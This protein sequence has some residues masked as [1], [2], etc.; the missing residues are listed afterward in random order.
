MDSGDLGQVRE[1]AV[2]AVRDPNMKEEELMKIFEM[3]K[4]KLTEGV[5][6]NPYDI[7]KHLTKIK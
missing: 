6:E 3:A 4:M 7:T 5:D 2:I 1:L